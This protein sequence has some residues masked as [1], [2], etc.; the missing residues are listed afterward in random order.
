MI[1]LIFFLALGYM[2]IRM[3]RAWFR[4]RFAMGAVKGF[5]VGSDSAFGART[6]REK[7][8]TERVHTVE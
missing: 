3:V 5:Q 7:D 1:K 2:I 6:G 8:I 4:V